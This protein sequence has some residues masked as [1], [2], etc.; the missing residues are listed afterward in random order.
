MEK[1]HTLIDEIKSRLPVEQ[2]IGE[3][4]ALKAAGGKYFKGLCP[5]HTE[6]TPSFTVTPDKGIFYCFGCQKKGSIFDFIME[7]E[8]LS[9]AESLVFL[10]KKAGL[11]PSLYEK[12]HKPEDSRRLQVFDLLE[13]ITMSFHYLLLNAPEAE[14]ARVYLEGR[15]INSESIKNFKLG[16]APADRRWLYRFLRQ[17]QFSD[18]LLPLTGLFL[19]KYPEVSFFYN[20]ILFPITNSNGQVLAFGGRIMEGG[21]GPKYINSQETDVFK[22]REQLYGI[23]QALPVIRAAGDCLLVEGYVDVIAMH[24]AGLCNSVAPLGTAFTPV[25]AQ[26]LRR[27]VENCVII[28]DSDNAGRQAAVRAVQV[29]EEEGLK[30]S[31]VDISGGKDPADILLSEGPE[32]LHNLVKYSINGFTYLLEDA[33][34][35]SNQSSKGAEIQTPEGKEKIVKTLMPYMNGLKSAVKREE[36]LKILSERIDIDYKALTR[37][38]AAF[39]TPNQPDRFRKKTEKEKK[40]GGELYVLIAVTMN[41]EYFT[42][43]RNS[44]DIDDLKDNT[45]RELY[46]SLEECFRQDNGSIENIVDKIETEWLKTVILE[47]ASSDEFKINP[48]QMIKDGIISVKR[49]SLKRRQAQLLMKLKEA[50]KTTELQ[51]VEDLQSELK[52]LDDEYRNMRIIW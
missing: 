23:S 26:F 18:E 36:C 19:P 49:Q 25:Q 38:L 11:D 8:H 17:K 12:K 22:K 29:C 2:L 7:I 1:D 37:D 9:F 10:G 42:N 16:W 3:Y 50:E 39:S 6:K 44:L 21:T 35:K 28:F 40:I 15:G 45:A 13:R 31:V 27:W 48:E 41:F 20:R 52:I 4:V 14:H 24:Q 32:A 47:K 46:I 34:R 30:C 33:I 43:V 51:L 5:F